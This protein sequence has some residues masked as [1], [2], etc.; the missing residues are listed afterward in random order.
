MDRYKGREHDA[1][2]R[3]FV[4]LVP[5]VGKEQD[6]TQPDQQC[7]GN[8]EGNTPPRSCLFFGGVAAADRA[9]LDIVDQPFLHPKIKFLQQP[10]D[11]LFHNWMDLSPRVPFPLIFDT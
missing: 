3:E 2:L 1:Q 4:H 6:H 11:V 9:G 7:P 5:V 8:S 10:V